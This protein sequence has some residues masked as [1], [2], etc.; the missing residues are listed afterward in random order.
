MPIYVLTGQ[1]EG[2]RLHCGGGRAPHWTRVAEDGQVGGLFSKSD[3][4][5]LKN[6]SEPMESLTIVVPL[7]VVWWSDE[8]RREEVSL[9][10]ERRQRRLQFAVPGLCPL[11][12]LR[13]HVTC[14]HLRRATR[15][16]HQRQHCKSW[17]WHCSRWPY[18][19]STSPCL[20]QSAIESLFGA[21]L[22]GVA[23]SLFGGQ[24]LIIL[25]STGPVLVFEK[26]L[27]QFCR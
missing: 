24:P 20:S 27:F 14:H 22:T 10:V 17:R 15:G 16:G 3:W 19:R 11:P 23:F 4:R 8:G 26:I 12:L 1:E 5:C 18:W 25:G 2:L 6:Q 13:M 21:S 9:L 7:Q